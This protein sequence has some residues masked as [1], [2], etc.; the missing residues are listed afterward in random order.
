MAD[1]FDFSGIRQLKLSDVE[2]LCGSWI[3]NGGRRSA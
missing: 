2:H 3:E 1:G